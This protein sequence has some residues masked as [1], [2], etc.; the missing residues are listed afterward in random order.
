MNSQLNQGESNQNKTV[1][2]MQL[3]DSQQLIN[4]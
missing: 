4:A 2:N 1:S 3:H